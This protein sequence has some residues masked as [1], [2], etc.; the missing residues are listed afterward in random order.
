MRII[1]TIMSGLAIAAAFLSSV[2][3]WGDAV[4]VPFTNDYEIPDTIPEY[5]VISTDEKSDWKAKWIWDKDNLTEKNVWMCFN[6]NVTLDEVPE[7]LIA[8]ISA[9]S[10]YWLYINGET[11]TFEGTSPPTTCTTTLPGSSSRSWR[12]RSPRACPSCSC[13]TCPFTRR[14]TTSRS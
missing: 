14:S 12:R 8:H 6:K 2:F 1:Q 10:K 3:S 5:S 7:K 11:A 4:M 9:D 13:A